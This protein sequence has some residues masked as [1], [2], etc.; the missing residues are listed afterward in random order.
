MKLVREKIELKAKI[1]SKEIDL[2][3]K[4]KEYDDFKVIID[5][6]KV[7]IELTRNQRQSRLKTLQMNKEFK[8]ENE[9]F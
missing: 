3:L 7:E 8:E 2:T 9:K 4:Q 6:Q 5:K 1:K